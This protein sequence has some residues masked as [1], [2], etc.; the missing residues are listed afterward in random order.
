MTER[1]SK[2]SAN[3]EGKWRGGT[4][5][6]IIAGVAIALIAGGSAPWWWSKVFPPYSQQLFTIQLNR[7]REIQEFLEGKSEYDLREVFDLNN[8][9]K[10]NFKKV[11]ITTTPKAFAQ[12]AID[13][14]E[15]F[16]KDGNFNFSLRYSRILSMGNANHPPMLQEIPGK[17]ARVYFSRKYVLARQ[18][19]QRLVSFTETPSSIRKKMNRFN[20]ALDQNTD[21]LLD[22]IN[23]NLDED[24][25]RLVHSDDPA[26]PYNGAASNT[27]TSH[28]VQLKPLADDAIAEIRKYLRIQ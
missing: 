18:Q 11:A 4:V 9:A 14:V 21:I 5:A 16:F 22:L 10:Y 8:V 19:F 2:H 23:E 28:S 20:E 12:S 27:Y 24:P 17:I 7:L 1:K 6:T 26:S 15:T 25:D 13:E 3:Q